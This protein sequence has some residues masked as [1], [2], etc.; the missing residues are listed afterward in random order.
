MEMMKS[1]VQCATSSLARISGIES[2][3]SKRLK[4]TQLSAEAVSKHWWYAMYGLLAL[5]ITLLIKLLFVDFGLYERLMDINGWMQY[6][7]GTKGLFLLFNLSTVASIIS[8]PPLA[9]DVVMNVVAGAAFGTVTGTCVYVLGTSFGCCIVFQ[10]LKFFIK[11]SLTAKSGY[12]AVHNPSTS[13]SAASSQQPTPATTPSKPGA[14]ASPS[15]LTSPA[16]RSLSLS[17][18]HKQADNGAHAQ[19]DSKSADGPAKPQHHIYGIQYL[20]Q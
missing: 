6:M 7:Q 3:N 11:P 15:S 19:D 8:V 18:F 9:V 16:V 5:A 12:K 14:K 4:K 20:E 17:P 10:S 1:S 2:Q 13:S